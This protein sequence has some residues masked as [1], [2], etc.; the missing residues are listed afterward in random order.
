MS[1]SITRA[2]DLRRVPWRNGQGLTTEIA[3]GG[4]PDR[5][6]W[7]VSRADVAHSGDFSLFPGIDRIIVLTDG[8]DITLEL[9]DR[10]HTLLVDKPF[11]FDGGLPIRCVVDGSARDLN[12]M[13]RRGAAAA[14]LTVWTSSATDDA[15]VLPAADHLVLVVLEGALSLAAADGT[16]VDTLEDG[17]AAVCTQPVTLAGDARV[18]AAQI[19]MS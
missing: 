1:I 2:A 4:P 16:V 17:D 6:D 13:T 15:L 11:C 7:R 10:T 18:A 3:V 8:P 14:S 9:P 19:A 5:F 12:V